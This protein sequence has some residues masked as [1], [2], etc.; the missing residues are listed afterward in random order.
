M[1]TEPRGLTR[2]W[3]RGVL[4]QPLGAATLETVVLAAIVPAGLLWGAKLWLFDSSELWLAFIPLLLGLRYGLGAGLAAG[5]LLVTVL[6]SFS[7]LA[8]APVAPFEHMD[9]V[10]LLLVGMTAGEI[11][12]GWASRIR[13]LE[14]EKDYHRIRLDQFTRAYHL[15]QASH[16]QLERQLGSNA[17]SLRT[18]LQ[19]L[20]LQRAFI[21]ANDENALDTIGKWLL[22][23]FADAGHLHTA[24]LYSVSERG[25]LQ[26]PAIATLGQPEELSAFDPLL[27]EALRSGCLTSL[28]AAHDTSA[29][30]VIAVVP[31]VDSFGRIHGVVSINEMPFFALRQSTF[32]LL[33]VLGG[34]V[35]DVLTRRMKSISDEQGIAAFK[36]C[37]QRTL[38]DVNTGSV[39]ASLVAYRI[40]VADP[41][42]AD[43]LA[44]LC[45]EGRG[46]DQNWICSDG[47]GYRIVLALLPLT[48]STGAQRFLDRIERYAHKHYKAAD[49]PQAFMSKVW[50]LG[51]EHNAE[52]LAEE[53]FIR[54][55]VVR[56]QDVVRVDD[57]VVAKVAE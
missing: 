45:H 30:D 21:A 48:D 39:P 19:R 15:L 17:V 51:A 13:R 32:D 56:P 28:R 23:L 14:S 49:A 55:E 2:R 44:R 42:Q 11:R 38:K 25:T 9:A 4:A 26:V 29:A 16:A 47:N 53:I 10:G 27:R 54:F 57:K 52:T 22:E 1:P 35:G 41:G 37:L 40:G 5:I 18:L 6:A 31:L 33:A 50:L 24:A 20:K 43:V 8:G 34:H 36:Q 7:H 46:L 12:D 3:R